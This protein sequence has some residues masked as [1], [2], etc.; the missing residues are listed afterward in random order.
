MGERGVHA[1]VVRHFPPRVGGIGDKH[2][3]LPFFLVFVSP[4]PEYNRR[5]NN[6]DESESSYH[7]SDYRA[8]N[9]V[10]LG[11][12]VYFRLTANIQRGNNN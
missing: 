3:R 7:T 2:R 12:R 11:A 5:Y 4:P 9:V 10:S 6:S 1:V 8:H